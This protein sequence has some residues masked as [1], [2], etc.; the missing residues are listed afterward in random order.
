MP[1]DY[2][3]ISRENE[4]KYGTDVGRFGPGLL[5]DLYAERAHFVFELLQN[6]E[7]ALNRRGG[8]GGYRSVRFEVADD[9]VRLSHFGVPF[10]EKDVRAV[11]GLAESTKEGELTT[12]GQFG[13]GFKSVYAVT[14][15]PEIHSGDEH[16]AIESYVH[17]RPTSTIPLSEGETVI[18]LPLQTGELAD[19]VVR[20]FNRLGKQRTLLFLR[21]ITEIAWNAQNGPSGYCRR[22]EVSE[23][24]DVRRIKLLSDSEDEDPIEESWLV[25]SREVDS[26]GESARHV[27]LAFN[28]ALDDSGKDVIKAVDRSPLVAFFPTVPETHL[29]MLVQGPYR[30]TSSCD[31][32]P[33]TD[34]WNR[35][36]V[37]ET[38]ALLVDALRWLRDRRMLGV[39]V[40][41]ALPLCRSLFHDDDSRFAAMFD[42]VRDALAREPLLPAHRGGYV[43]ASN[44]K[45]TPDKG[46][47]DLTSRP[48][49]AQL[50]GEDEPVAWLTG[51]I[52]ESRTPKLYDYLTDEHGIAEIDTSYL[53]ELLDKQFLEDQDDKWIRRLYEFLNRQRPLLDDVP[54]IR[55]E[56]GTHVAPDYGS[57]P[58][59]FLPTDARSSPPN[60]VR[61][62]VCDSKPALE[63]LKWLGLSEVDRIDAIIRDVIPKYRKRGKIDESR[64]VADL[65]KIVDA[66]CAASPDRK[67]LLPTPSVRLTSSAR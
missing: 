47:R 23:S 5:G 21:E 58:I 43:S 45:L 26:D 57:D 4:K 40:F 17:P 64:Y 12:I 9:C 46:L 55:L 51:D 48:R 14:E 24:E 13:I 53:L 25:F 7:D 31:N 15:R 18:A 27:E 36:L 54:L 52:T 63:F 61:P 37:K 10:T 16:F 50:L 38:A 28:L 39:H 29:G 19:D 2:E 41:D 60:T 32:I 59:A 3:Q 6:A 33:Q 56:D 35:H 49:L 67:R 30:T 62:T 1:S 65:R 34:P 66:Y 8:P 11:C 22:E 44:A 20:Q 42:A